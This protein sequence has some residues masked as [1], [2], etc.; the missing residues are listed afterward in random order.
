MTTGGLS[1][2]DKTNTDSL[3]SIIPPAPQFDKTDKW[4]QARVSRSRALAV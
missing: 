3:L 2:F 4:T 1:A